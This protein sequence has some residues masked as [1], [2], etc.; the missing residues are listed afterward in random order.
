MKLTAVILTIISI[1]CA[2]YSQSCVIAIQTGG[3]R[4]DFSSA[5]ALDPDGNIIV[6]GYYMTTV[7]FDPG[8][9]VNSHTALGGRD[10]Y[11]CKFDASLNLIWVQTWG[12]T[13]DETGNGVTTD[14]AGDIY[15]V[16]RYQGTVD[17]NPGVGVDSRTSNAGVANNI[18]LSKY[19]SNGNYRWTKTFG[20]TL[21]C[22]GYSVC[23]DSDGFV[24]AVGDFQ[25]SFDFDPGAGTDIHTNNGF[26]DAWLSKFDLDGNIVWTRTWGGTAYDD[27]PSVAVDEAHNVYDSG[28]FM[29]VGADFDPGAGTDFH[30]SNGAI[31]GFVSK[32][33]SNGN[34]KWART[35]GGIGEDDASHIVP[36][37]HGNLYIFGY[38][39]DTVDFDPG[40]ATSTI[41]SNGSYDVFL[42]KFDTLGNFILM[43]RYGGIGTDKS[44]TGFI[45]GSGNIYQ[46]GSFCST[47]DFNPGAGTYNLTSGGT[48]DVFITKLDL[49][50]NFVWAKQFGG[51][52]I[53]MGSSIVIDDTQ[54][55]ISSG[56]FTLNADFDPGTATLNLTSAGTVDAFLCKLY[57]C[58]IEIKSDV[59]TC[60]DGFIVSPNP[61]HETV[62]ISPDRDIAYERAIV[63]VFDIQ[64]R[65]VQ[66]NTSGAFKKISLDVETLKSGVYFVKIEINGSSVTKKLIVE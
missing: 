5:V 51:G 54:N 25:G 35:W 65:L 20:G 11:V 61:A 62:F 8:S 3:S 19:D 53:E 44:F 1:F 6:V 12:G 50:C 34:F 4:D 36:D 37:M 39:C 64:G 23:Y 32:F 57:N 16:G 52:G 15:I 28:M 41:V 18:F 13:N 7:D 66:K 60:T 24:Y 49:S 45:D 55:V 63:S 22:E 38:F 59:S 40:I 10:V 56:T 17:F 14:S 2:V 21:G 33:D 47:V 29:S 31:D 30:S 48:T 42:S 26:F 27:G 43:K 9:A 46:I 58:A